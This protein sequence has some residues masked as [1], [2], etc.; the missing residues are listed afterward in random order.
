MVVEVIAIVEKDLRTEMSLYYF[1]N[2][3]WT[4]N[5]ISGI[6]YHDFLFLDSSIVGATGSKTR[7]T[8]SR[9]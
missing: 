1:K 7:E 2:S 4:L 9:L 5:L 8:G 6:R 3:M